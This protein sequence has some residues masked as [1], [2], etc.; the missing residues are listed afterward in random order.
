MRSNCNFKI[1]PY[2]NL[3]MNEL[4]AMNSVHYIPP[5]L[6]KKEIAPAG[7]KPLSENHKIME[8]ENNKT[9][10]KVCYG[11]LLKEYVDSSSKLRLFA[12]RFRNHKF[13]TNL[14][15]TV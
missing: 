3:K 8:S 14:D 2:C 1:T 9:I 11:D 5:T 12:W 4:M 10:A 13:G 7:T 15:Q 6:N